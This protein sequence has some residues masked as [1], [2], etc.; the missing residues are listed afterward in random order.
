LNVLKSQ[1]SQSRLRLKNNILVKNYRQLSGSFLISMGVCGKLM[2]DF[3]ERYGGYFMKKRVFAL[4]LAGAMVL[5]ATSCGKEED[6]TT[7]SKETDSK[8]E[9]SQIEYNVDDYVTLGDYKGIEVNLEGEYEYT[10]E[11]FDKYVSETVFA[12]GI[13]VADE[14][15]TEV[16][17]DSIVN[18][19]YV[20]SQDGV[21]FDG[22]SAENQNLDVANNCAAG[23]GSGYIDGFTAGLVGAKVGEETAYEV[24]FPEDYGNADLAGQTVTFTFQVNYVAKEADSLDDLTDDYVS[25]NYGYDTVDE[26]LDYLKESYESK[27]TSNLESDTETAVLNALI[28]N[29]T[30]SEVPADLL[31]ARIDLMIQIQNI[32]LESYGTTF[33]DYIEAMGY[34]YDDIYQ[35]ITDTTTESTKTELI[36]EAIAKAEGM[37]VDEDGYTKWITEIYEQ[38]GYSDL[39]SLYDDFTV[40]GY[41]G[42]KYFELAY[43]TESAS[44]FCVENAVVNSTSVI[45]EDTSEEAVEE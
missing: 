42:Q 23:G 45:S 32:Q 37:E 36:L 7:E 21:A 3:C 6:A 20:G 9:T 39:E 14:S 28:N 11:G 33:E 8:T 13:Y 2:Q 24:T 5:S 17:E 41:S 22:G 4:A 25:T 12:T 10:D 40:D 19:D 29:C 31:Q 44:D 15:Q 43:L 27:L 16:A 1:L 26:Y 18:V 38:M 30:V 34:E 35:Q